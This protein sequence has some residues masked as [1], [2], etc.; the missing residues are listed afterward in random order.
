MQGAKINLKTFSNV[1]KGEEKQALACGMPLFCRFPDIF[2]IAKCFQV[3]F[4]SL[5]L[6][7]VFDKKPS[8]CHDFGKV[9]LQ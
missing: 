2:D 7:S 6:C 9:N 5:Q 1:K 3:N 4:C 8:R